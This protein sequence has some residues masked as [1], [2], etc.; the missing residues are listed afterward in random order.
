M[1]RL[2]G[3]MSW[4]QTWRG[5]WEDGSQHPSTLQTFMAPALYV[6]I[7]IWEL[8]NAEVVINFQFTMV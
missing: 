4:D 5:A 3:G 7:L 1:K 8:S 6:E 2:F